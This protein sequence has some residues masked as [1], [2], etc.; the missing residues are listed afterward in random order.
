MIFEQKINNYRDIFIEYEYDITKR[1]E[2]KANNAVS[3]C[4]LLF[5]EN[6]NKKRGDYGF[7]RLKPNQQFNKGEVRVW[8]Y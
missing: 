3:N 2:T 6:N 4:W 1:N 7:F 5:L 8:I